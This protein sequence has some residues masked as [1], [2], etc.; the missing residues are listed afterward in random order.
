MVALFE[1]RRVAM[2]RVF[3]RANHFPSGLTDSSLGLPRHAALARSSAA[4]S[5][6]ENTSR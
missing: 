2:R 5:N 3:L 4:V 6:L 1:T